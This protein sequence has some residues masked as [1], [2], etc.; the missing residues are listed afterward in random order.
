MSNEKFEGYLVGILRSAEFIYFIHGQESIASNLIKNLA[1]GVSFGLLKKICKEEN[2][3]N[4]NRL[5]Y[6]L[7][8][9]S[10]E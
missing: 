2:F 10:I 9:K 1:N 8:K 6:W 7:E 4:A 5:V 3:K